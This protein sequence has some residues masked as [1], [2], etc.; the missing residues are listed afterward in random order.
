M[1]TPVRAVCGQP[2]N[3]TCMSDGFPE[4]SYTITHNGSLISNKTKH[5]IQVVNWSD[6]GTYKCLA[7]NELGNDS[8]STNFTVGKIMLHSAQSIKTKVC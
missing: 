3:I 4:P 2:V 6:S 5:T 8:A 1:F 7:K